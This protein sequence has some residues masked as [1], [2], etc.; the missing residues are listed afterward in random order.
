VDLSDFTAWL[1]LIHVL[2]A[3]VWV[4]GNVLTV[5][6][7]ARA[8]ASSDPAD[9][10]RF[11]KDALVSGRVFAASGILTLI[12]GVWM[13]LR[14]EFWGFDQAWISIG[15]IG[16]LLGAILGPAFYAPQAKALIA[17]SEAGDPAAEARG[18]RIGQVSTLEVLVLLVVVWAMVFKP[19]L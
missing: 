4:G 14:E 18:R 15:F 5:I 1:K 2:A 19:G 13:V 16:I 10:I 3:I 9:R 17:E 8:G 6:H 7:G 11:A 12:A